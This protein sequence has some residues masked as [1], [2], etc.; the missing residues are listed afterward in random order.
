MSMNDWDFWNKVA[1]I[2]TIL[3]IPSV[4]IL[5]FSLWTRI[6]RLLYFNR[7]TYIN[8]RLKWR[9]S[10]DYS[11]NNGKYELGTEKQYFELKFSKSSWTNIILYNDP[12]SIVWV[13]IAKWEYEITN[14]KNASI[15]DMSSRTRRP[16]E[17]EIAILKNIHWNYC[18]LKILDVKDDTRE[19]G[20]DEVTFEYMV[21]NEWF[22]DFRN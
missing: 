16:N 17:W 7:Q 3:W 21:N 10:F 12:P 2:V 13:A 14:I 1:T 8:K 11:N 9:V 19:D 4:I 5:Y 6:S 20:V 15:Y 18:A 22:T